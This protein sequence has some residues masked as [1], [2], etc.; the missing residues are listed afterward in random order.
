M[1]FSPSLVYNKLRAFTL[2]ELL[3][4]ITIIAILA[5]L[6][7]PAIGAVRENAR[8]VQAKNDVTNI[9][10]AVKNYYTE[11]GKYPATSTSTTLQGFFG[12]SPTAPTGTGGTSTAAQAMLSGSGSMNTRQIVYLELPAVKNTSMPNSGVMPNTAATN[13]G[14]Y[15]D[16]WGSPYNVVIDT[17]YNNT[18][19]NP[20]KDPQNAGGSYLNLGVISYAYGKNG[21]LGGGAAASGTSGVTYSAEGGSTGNYNGSGDVISWQ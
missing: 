3:V 6:I 8:K 20:Y 12:T 14:V 2:I 10:N 21:Q 18:I 5:G 19:T 9:V 7:F 1:K 16:P 13:V 17:L 11:Y 15:Y 4:V